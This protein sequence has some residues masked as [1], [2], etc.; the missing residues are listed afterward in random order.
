MFIDE[1]HTIIGAGAASGGVMDASNLIKPV[2]ASGDTDPGLLLITRKLIQAFAK[3][4]NSQSHQHNNK[5]S[6]NKQLPR[7]LLQTGSA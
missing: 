7:K 6:Q 3:P 2:L 4:Q 5:T 1:I